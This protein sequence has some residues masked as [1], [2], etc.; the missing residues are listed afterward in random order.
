MLRM[1]PLRIHDGK[2]LLKRLENAITSRS[3]DEGE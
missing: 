2:G 1:K 3:K